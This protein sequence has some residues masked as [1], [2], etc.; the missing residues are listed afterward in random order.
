MSTLGYIYS[1]FFDII[2][3]VDFKNEW[4]IYGLVTPIGAS[5]DYAASVDYVNSMVMSGPTGPTGD[6]GEAGDVGATGPQGPTGNAGSSYVTVEGYTGAP[7]PTGSSV[8]ISQVI[9]IKNVCSCIVVENTEAITID[10]GTTNRAKDIAENVIME[11]NSIV[12]CTVNK[13]YGTTGPDTPIYIS[14]TN[15]NGSSL[16]VSINCFKG[17]E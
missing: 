10:I 15:W 1:A 13:M 7:G 11:E 17:R 2:S 4:S 5:G 9:P 14:S 3:D 8:L 12:T 16:N 6:K